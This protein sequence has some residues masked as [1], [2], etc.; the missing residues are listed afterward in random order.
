MRQSL[1]MLRIFSVISVLQLSFLTSYSTVSISSVSVA[2]AG[3]Y[4]NIRIQ[5]SEWAQIQSKNCD[6]IPQQP[7][8]AFILM[9]TQTVYLIKFDLFCLC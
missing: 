1:S 7:N 6:G 4:N 9:L 5:I 2:E 3:M 8:L